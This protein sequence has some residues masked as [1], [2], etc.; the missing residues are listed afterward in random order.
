MET[1]R[2][3]FWLFFARIYESVLIE[4]LTWNAF[5]FDSD[6]FQNL[7]QLEEVDLN[8]PHLK[9]WNSNKLMY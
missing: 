3:G 6:C 2:Q 5:F 9:V 8:C 7:M 4:K 1:D